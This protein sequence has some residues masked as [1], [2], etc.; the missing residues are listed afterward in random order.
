[1]T[2]SDNVE[3]AVDGAF[4][5]AVTQAAALGRMVSQMREHAIQRAARQEEA[6]SA[7]LQRRYDAERQYARVMLSQADHDGWWNTATTPQVASVVATAQAWKD[8]DPEIA[9]LASRIDDRA[10]A[11]WGINPSARIAALSPAQQHQ[12]AQQLSTML[13]LDELDPND[14]LHTFI[15]DMSHLGP[16]TVPEVPEDDQKEPQHNEAETQT[17]KF[18]QYEMVNER[19][20]S[21]EITK[22]QAL[23]V[24]ESLPE[25]AT[26]SLNGDSRNAIGD[27]QS[28]IGKD[29]QV[30][31]AIVE[32]FPHLL[33]TEQRAAFD[34]DQ[35]LEEFE[36]LMR[37][38]GLDEE[39]IR[40]Q[41]SPERANT[42]PPIEAVNMESPTKAHRGHE[43]WTKHERQRD[44]EHER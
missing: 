21:H 29:Q 28:W 18:Y 17:P 4:R 11:R 42:K 1:M 16:E 14:P 34:R 13:A 19:D 27:V 12:E 43:H 10:Q 20:S 2:E 30:D 40:A 31:Q 23:E 25:D 6:M 7:Q 35:Q 5:S 36:A 15:A 33:T 3:Q 24:I 44:T 41:T 26:I 38:N 8:R 32:K 39:T 37:S 9:R 22:A